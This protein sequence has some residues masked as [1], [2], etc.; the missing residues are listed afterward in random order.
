MNSVQLPETYLALSDF[1]KHDVYL[2]EMNPTQIIADYFPGSFTELTQRLSDIT[3]SFYG[4]ILKQAGKLYGDE[5]IEQLSRSFMHDL[6]SKM[7]MRNFQAKPDLK[8]GIPAFAHILIAA[9]FTS[10]PEYNFE[11]KELNDHKS[12]F[13]IKGADRYHRITQDLQIAN[14]LEWP[15]IKPFIHGIC[16]T[17]GLD[18]SME[19]KVLKLEADSSCIYEITVSKN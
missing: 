2:P 6:G 12:K 5:A 3:S 11:F 1:R 9:I 7:V 15:V 18:V 8:P 19:V 13:L 14:Q 17:M 16:N 4:G 10:S